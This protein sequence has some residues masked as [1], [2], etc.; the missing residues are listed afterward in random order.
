MTKRE[1]KVIG[2][3]DLNE[4]KEFNFVASE[5]ADKVTVNMAFLKRLTDNLNTTSI[6]G[7]ITQFKKDLD[8]CNNSEKF[9]AV[10]EN[11][12]IFHKT[13]KA[14]ESHDPNAVEEDKNDYEFAH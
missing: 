4:T 9:I 6:L 8:K 2:K 3:I 10:L 13:V 11:E 1:P 5:D 12:L 14:I 7:V